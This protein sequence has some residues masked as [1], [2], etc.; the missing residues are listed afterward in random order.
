MMG[1]PFH[2]VELMGF[3]PD[4]KSFRPMPP[5]GRA[6]KSPAE[7]GDRAVPALRGRDDLHA[8]I[9]HGPHGRRQIV[10]VAVAGAAAVGIIVVAVG[11]AGSPIEDV[12]GNYVK[13]SQA[14]R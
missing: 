11:N 1:A 8:G 3:D 4:S 5:P 6:R 12:H 14:V 7:F 10:P 2:G 13:E 9:P